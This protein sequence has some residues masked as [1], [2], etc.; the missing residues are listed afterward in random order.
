[1]AGV[2]QE[3]WQNTMAGVASFTLYLINPTVASPYAY[4]YD[5]E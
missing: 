3:D 2:L 1:V 5:N 4:A